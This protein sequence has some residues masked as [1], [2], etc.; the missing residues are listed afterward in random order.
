M[1]MGTG[2]VDLGAVKTIA[3]LR[4]EFKNG[5]TVT[6]VTID[7]LIDT[8]AEG[9]ILVVG[10]TEPGTDKLWL[11]TNYNLASINQGLNKNIAAVAQQ[12]Y[13]PAAITV[14]SFSN[15]GG[16]DNSII[17]I[18]NG[19]TGQ[20]LMAWNFIGPYI[21]KITF[22]VLTDVNTVTMYIQQANGNY[23][24]FS[25]LEIWNE[26]LTVKFL[27]IDNLNYGPNVIDT[28]N[29]LPPATTFVF[30]CKNLFSSSNELSLGEL[31]INGGVNTGIIPVYGRQLCAHDGSTWQ[32]IG[33]NLTSLKTVNGKS[34]IGTGDITQDLSSYATTA[35]LTSAISSIVQGTPNFVPTSA[36]ELGT[37]YPQGQSYGHVTDGSFPIAGML[38]NNFD[39]NL[40]SQLLVGN[41]TLYLRNG[42]FGQLVFTEEDLFGSSP[43][44]VDCSGNNHPVSNAFDGNP[45]SDWCSYPSD[46][47]IT[48]AAVPPRRLSSYT[49]SVTNFRWPR[50]F[51]ISGKIA[52]Q[53][54]EIIDSQSGFDF[55]A[56]SGSRTITVPLTKKYDYF[57]FNGWN[58][59]NGAAYITTLQFFGPSIAAQ[60]SLITGWGAFTQIGGSSSSVQDLSGYALTTDVA[61]DIAVETTRATTAEAAIM[62]TLNSK[63]KTITSGTAAPTGGVDGDIYLQHS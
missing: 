54:W 40:M 32:P 19:D 16:H 33:L 47:D 42:A 63:Q 36:N 59:T 11:N 39:G 8:L 56:P 48:I 15:F 9:A 5:D 24:G 55:S 17:A 2:T 57:R 34:V 6:Q 49:V 10:S 51:N 53:E 21:F 23:N 12:S 7:D 41:S 50:N 4:D 35:A 18:K 52:G 20:G 45:G 60:D 14:S 58:C 31:V 13:T 22:D 28:S 43:T 37:S 44:I 62:T 30:V 3:Q 1:G 46:P 29:I 26:T 27:D 38:I 25:G 61:T